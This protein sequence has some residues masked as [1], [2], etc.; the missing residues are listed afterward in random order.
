MMGTGNQHQATFL[1]VINPSN[2][3][4]QPSFAVFC[5]TQAS[6][7]LLLKQTREALFPYANAV[8]IYQV[9]KQKNQGGHWKPNTRILLQ[10]SDGSANSVNQS[11]TALQ[12][13]QS[14]GTPQNKKQAQSTRNDLLFQKSSTWPPFYMADGGSIEAKAMGKQVQIWLLV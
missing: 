6:R 4:T 5:H 13:L 7:P 1:L 9:P 12:L 14:S 2:T 10:D 11:S 3:S 8:I